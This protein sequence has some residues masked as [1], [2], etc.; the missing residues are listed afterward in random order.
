M[1]NYWHK[2]I[3]LIILVL[4]V[5]QLILSA[6][7]S[8]NDETAATYVP[9]Y[10]SSQVSYQ[11]SIDENIRYVLPESEVVLEYLVHLEHNVMQYG[12]A[13]LI[14]NY[15]GPLFTYIRF[16]QAGNATDEI[17]FEWIHDLYYELGAEFEE[18]R[19]YSS[20]AEG[21]INVNFNS[22][23][24]MDKYAGVVFHGMFMHSYMANPRDIVQVFNI[25]VSNGSI[26]ENTDIL[27]YDNFDVA[28][29]LLRERLLEMNPNLE[30]YLKD[31]DIDKNWFDNIA[32]GSDGIIVILEKYEH[33]PGYIGTLMIT[34]P[35]DELGDAL[36]IGLEPYASEVP[37]FN[38][39]VS[40]EISDISVVESPE[41]DTLIDD[42]TV[43]DIQESSQII[44]PNLELDSTRPMIALTFDDGPSS[45]HTGR[46]LDL[47]EQYGGRATFFVL[48]NLVNDNS[49]IVARAHQNGNEILGHSWNHRNLTNLSNEEIRRQILDTNA[50]IE[51]VTG[52][53][54]NMFRAPF[55]AVNANVR[56][57]AQELGFA[58]VNWSIDP[59][60]WDHRDAN[61]TYSSIINNARSGS[62]V[63]LHDIHGS[64]ADAMERVIPEL[65]SRGYQ[66]V[67]VSELLAYSDRVVAAGG[68]INN[69]Y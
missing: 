59:R 30:A 41:S 49:D 64:T 27:D 1:I 31:A 67:T 40:E 15:D 65:V 44:L 46:I 3:F 55:G 5:S 66:L 35:Y 57:I 45:R 61:R 56:S 63:V 34:L 7:G 18:T 16:P 68:V 37:E 47:L 43:A 60:D 39:V 23:M 38:V 2:R 69:G 13:Y 8:S 10:A 53:Q 32:I 42:T 21:E 50:V 17:I 28:A 4:A 48:G 52:I 6:C 24:F 33:F 26:L 25:D 51:S 14:M 11:T 12:H 20:A 29:K 54:G 58:I 62:I 9:D 22:Y 19:E 36:I